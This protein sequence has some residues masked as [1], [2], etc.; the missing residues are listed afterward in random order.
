M[1]LRRLLIYPFCLF[2]IFFL[3]YN[4]IDGNFNTNAIFGISIAITYLIIDLKIILGKKK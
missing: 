4:L 1:T 3:L 2:I